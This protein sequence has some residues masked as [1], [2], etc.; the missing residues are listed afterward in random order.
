MTS[1]PDDIGDRVDSVPGMTELLA[2]LDPQPPVYLVGGAVRDVLLDRPPVDIDLAVEG[3]A[4]AVARTLAG[5]LGGVA[6]EHGRFGTAS[7]RAPAVSADL[8]TTRTETYSE[9]GALPDVA[10]AGIDA[11]LRRRDFTVNAVAAMLS[12]DGP[13]RI[14][15]P[16]GGRADIAGALIRTLHPGSF[17][18]DPTRLLRAVRYAARL[19]FELEGDTERQARAAVGAGVLRTVSGPRVRD[20]LLD[21]LAEP[22]APAALALLAALGIDRGLHPV[23]RADPELVAGVQLA[24]ADTGA[25]RVL[26]ALAGLVLDDPDGAAGWVEDLGL[27]GRDRDAVLRAAG[28]GP[29]LAELLRSELRRSEL[30]RLLDPEPP[31]ALAVA[32]GLGA[33]GDPIL[34]FVG[35]LRGARLAING[36]DLLAAGVPE[37]PAI[38]RA[39]DATLDRVLDGE[40][41]GRDEQLA[42]ALE[43]AL[44]G[45]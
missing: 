28:R 8:A 13:G 44:E 10:P 19:G 34:R 24:A 37:S 9:P 26:A 41:D 18:D 27:D 45:S 33:P 6:T 43:L 29:E 14:L 11:D 16:H 1:L 15:D 39:L 30:Y 7:V 35:D 42:A 31:E 2:A 12:G 40:V 5:R 38:G 4:P 36:D 20:E 21:L 17:V 3:D 25:D 23:L 22:E 32:L